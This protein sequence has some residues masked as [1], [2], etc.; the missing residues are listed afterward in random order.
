MLQG[1]SSYVSPVHQVE[2][3][4]VRARLR[5]RRPDFFVLYALAAVAGMASGLVLSLLA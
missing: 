3:V 4:R 1:H 2:R 5:G